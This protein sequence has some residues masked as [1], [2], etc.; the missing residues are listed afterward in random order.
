MATNSP[1]S[2]P[3]VTPPST[4]ELP[5][6][7]TY[8]FSMALTSRYAI[9]SSRLDARLDE[10]H[11]PVAQEPDGPDGDDAQDDVGVDEAVVLLPEEPAHARRAREHLGG[12][13]DQP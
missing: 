6:E 7:V 4:R 9:G 10:A 8:D 3:R 11:Q 12:H 1:A 5:R 2:R 13:D